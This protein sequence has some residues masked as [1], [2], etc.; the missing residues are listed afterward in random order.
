MN[1][2]SRP[3]GLSM[4][5]ALMLFNKL[6]LVCLPQQLFCSASC[7]ISLHRRFSPRLRSHFKKLQLTLDWRAVSFHQKQQPKCEV[8]EVKMGSISEF[9]ERNYRHFNAAVLKEAADAYIAHL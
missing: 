3:R 6:R 8:D 7:P 9:I 1:R 4:A 5:Y 2:Q